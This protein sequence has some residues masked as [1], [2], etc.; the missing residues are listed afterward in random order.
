MEKNAFGPVETPEQPARINAGRV[1]DP[2][3]ALASAKDLALGLG[4]EVIL[5]I[6]ID[7]MHDIV[8]VIAYN[9]TIHK[10]QVDEVIILQPLP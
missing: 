10:A 4:K 8:Y 9:R 3:N 1:K 7:D 6:R 5:R 2:S